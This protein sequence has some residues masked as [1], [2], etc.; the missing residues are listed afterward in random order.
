M[1]V[2][3]QW[4]E[5][6]FIGISIGVSNIERYF[7]K[8]VTEIELQIDHLRIACN[9]NPHFWQDRP[10]IHDPRLCAWLESKDRGGKAR[11]EPFLLAMIPAGKNSFVLSP[12]TVARA[13]AKP[14]RAVK[15]PA[16]K[17]L[18]I[19]PSLQPQPL[20]GAAA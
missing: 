20:A 14:P 18:V 3:S 4:N 16:A 2:S 7:P 19:G 15:S 10:E 6:R 13:T 17:R 11:R 1:V 5:N 8:N 12:I 9:L